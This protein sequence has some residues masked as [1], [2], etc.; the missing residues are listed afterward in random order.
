M[1]DLGLDG[2]W[3]PGSRSSTLKCARQS[4]RVRARAQPWTGLVRRCT[5][6]I[7]GWDGA[8]MTRPFRPGGISRWSL[9]TGKFAR[10]RAYDSRNHEKHYDPSTG[11]GVGDH[12]RCRQLRH[13][14][15]AGRAASACHGH[16]YGSGGH[17]ACSHHARGNG[18]DPGAKDAPAVRRHHDDIDDSGSDDDHCAAFH[19]HSPGTLFQ[20]G[21]GGHAGA[22]CSSTRV[23]WDQVQLFGA[24]GGPPTG[25]I[26]ARFATATAER[27][28][29]SNKQPAPAARGAI[30]S[31]DRLEQN[32]PFALRAPTPCRVLGSHRC[33]RLAAPTCSL[34]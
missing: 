4:C 32:A 12:A 14:H 10:K 20:H 33:A 24:A 17:C 15:Q 25:L 1:N 3:R 29:S 11:H 34:R 19:G 27:L 8:R 2:A 13:H 18:H 5:G 9:R 21:S 16:R 22:M 30:R 28:S 6:R 7:R 26:V 31:P 23:G